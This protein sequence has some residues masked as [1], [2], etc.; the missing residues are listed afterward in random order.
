MAT[1]LLQQ[2]GRG[3]EQVRRVRPSLAA[4]LRVSAIVELAT[5]CALLAVP[6]LVIQA[7]VGSRW[8][9]L[10]G[11]WELSPASAQPGR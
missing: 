4:T 6:S 11:L 1:V 2:D 8:H 7:L 3:V 10:D 5:G 9:K